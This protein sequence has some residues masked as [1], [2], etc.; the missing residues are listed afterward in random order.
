[1]YNYLHI[2]M[3]YLRIHLTKENID[4]GY[5][6][7]PTNQVEA[8]DLG[9]FIHPSHTDTRTR[10]IGETLKF[11]LANQKPL[12]FLFSFRTNNDILYY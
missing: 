12:I 4:S 1:M 10:L 8:L 11:K 6:A 5:I 9:H 7:L 3:T 2:T